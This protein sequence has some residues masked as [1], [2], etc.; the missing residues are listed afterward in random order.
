MAQIVVRSV[1][2]LKT[3][4]N[5]QRLPVESSEQQRFPGDRGA[6]GMGSCGRRNRQV[7]GLS[8][9]LCAGPRV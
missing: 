8:P 3:G 5:A 9:E 7:A 1:F 4:R 2:L 6:A